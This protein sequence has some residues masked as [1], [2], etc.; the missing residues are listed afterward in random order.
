[1][2]RIV[3]IPQFPQPQSGIP[4]TLTAGAA[5]STQ[6]NLT[7]TYGGQVPV[8][9]YSF[10][11]LIGFSWTLLVTQ[12][13]A[14]ASSTGLSP[15][16]T[17][18]YRVTV[19][20]A[21]GRTSM[22]SPVASAT[23]Q[24]L[25]QTAT[26]TFSPSGG[27]FTN[28]VTVAISDT[29]LGASIYYT[30][31]GLPPTTGSTL[32]TGPITVSST[33]TVQAVAQAPGSTVSNVGSASYTIVA[34]GSLAITTTTLGTPTVGGSFFQTMQASG[35]QPPYQWGQVG[36]N[37]FGGFNYSVNV[38]VSA[39]TQTTNAVFTLTSS[40]TT[41][42]FAGQ[43]QCMVYPVVGSWKPNFYQ[44]GA[45]TATGGSSGAWTVTTNI[46]FSNSSYGL[47]NGVNELVPCALVAGPTGINPYQCTLTGVLEVAATVAE[48]ASLPFIVTDNTGAT[49]IAT[50]PITVTS[51]LAIMGIDQSVAIQNL[52]QAMQYNSYQHTFTC[53]GG[54]GTGQV[55]TISGLP[56]GITASGPVISG[57]P[58]GV[59]STDEISVTVTDSA[60]PPVTAFFN[61]VVLANAN[62]AR[63]SYNT[64]TSFFVANGQLYDPNG[65]PFRMRGFNQNHYDD[66][67][68]PGMAAALGCNTIRAFCFLLN[69][70]GG[71]PASVYVPNITSILSKNMLPIFT[72]SAVPGLQIN[73]ATIT[74]T[75]GQFS[76]AATNLPILVGAYVNISGTNTGTGSISGYGSGTDYLVSATNGSTTFTLTT[77]SGGALTTVAGSTTGWTYGGKQKGTSGDPSTADLQTCAN[78]LAANYSAFPANTAF[79]IANEWNG[80]TASWQS[81]Y[82]AAVSTIRTA[83]CTNLLMIDANGDGQNYQTLTT[84]AAAVQA[85]DPQQN[86]VFSF[87]A[88]GATQNIQAQITSITKGSSN[89]V[90]GIN[91]TGPVNPFA[92]YSI[93]DNVNGTPPIFI[94]G[95]AGMTQINGFTSASNATAGGTSGAYTITFPLNS[96]AFSTYTSGGT[97][98]SSVHIGEVIAPALAALASSNVCC[99]IGE[100]GPGKWIGTNDGSPTSCTNAQ[101]VAA[102]EANNIGWLYWAIDDNNLNGAAVSQ[103]WFGAGLV[104]GTYTNATSLT[105]VGLDAALNPNTG[106]YG[107]ATPASSFVGGTNIPVSSFDFFISTT[108]SDSNA[109]SLAAPW[110]ITAISSHQSTYGGKRLGIIAG[111]YN[112]ATA[113]AALG[114]NDILLNINGGPSTSQKTYVAACDTSGNYLAPTLANGGPFVVIN[115]GTTANQTN[116]AFVIGCANTLNSPTPTN[117][118][119][120]I[121]DGIAIR[122]FWWTPVLVG[123]QGGS[124]V[125][126]W[127]IQNCEIGN[128]SQNQT[129]THPAAIDCGSSQNGLVTNC[130]IH[131]IVNT[132]ADADHQTGLEQWGFSP[133]S[134][135]LT[136]DHCTFT[137][138]PGVYVVSRAGDVVWG[139][140]VQYCFFDLTN[141]GV[142]FNSGRAFFGGS[143]LDSPSSQLSGSSFHHNI[144]K[145]GFSMQDCGTPGTA[146]SSSGTGNWVTTLQLY[147]NTWDLAGYS[148]PANGFRMSENAGQSGLFSCYNNLFFDNGAGNFSGPNGYVASNVDGFAVLNYNIYG[149]KNAF[150]TFPSGATSITGANEQISFASWKTATGGDANSTTNATN[151]FNVNF[152]SGILAAAYQ[153]ASGSVAFQAGKVGGISS[154]ATC[155]AGAWDGTV[156]QIGCSFAQDT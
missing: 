100:V 31:N 55:W 155:N 93:G 148:A 63:P 20:T 149:T 129:T 111:T 81:A 16:T 136:V 27:T 142:N 84:L 150:T 78:W 11:I 53:A 65:A 96:S 134:F 10:Y 9:S 122:N 77:S 51:A 70:G 35:G 30:T 152:S 88:Y 151:P 47:N 128:G 13:G 76:C 104:N 114:T 94:T 66:S 97:I 17:Y 42:P 124:P 126:N 43:T 45:I 87:H 21:D 32:Y 153:V 28:S 25:T 121:L 108:G 46:D 80:A 133:Q 90:V 146:S 29:T 139:T 23:T 34:G 64:G 113:L 107:L 82:E 1:M 49:A 105:Y 132:A 33:E 154:G 3:S 89:T 52:P 37:L 61:L 4:V 6:I 36:A 92:N 140:T 103:N 19:T 56:S 156:T 75:A 12:A 85:S 8:V 60:G 50:L 54:T 41:H 116:N 112:V 15:S 125:S 57:I 62:V 130:W 72:I 18:I 106:V 131:D 83:G 123:A 144:V 109:G 59:D 24:T 101:V 79:N 86:C 99:V 68:A 22:P 145:G 98:Y 58:T 73:N 40:A 44:S 69:Q 95:A 115:C 48:T 143:C 39:I 110:S 119:N 5:S 137:N 118:G 7:A 141:T 102:A 147:N 38:P 71:W 120:F 91:F 117:L 67:G 138:S 26:P 135:G 127:V 14:T 2:R 74:G